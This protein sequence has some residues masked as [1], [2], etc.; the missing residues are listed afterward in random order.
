MKQLKHKEVANSDIHNFSL[1]TSESDCL[2][3]TPALQ[4]IQ[5]KHSNQMQ[6]PRTLPSQEIFVNM[7]T[8]QTIPVQYMGMTSHNLFRK[9]GQ[10]YTLCIHYVVL[11]DANLNLGIKYR[12]L[13]ER[14]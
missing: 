6:S 2:N 9:L 3:K 14:I 1:A 10:R 4:T 12:Q 5:R 7:V 11:N 13:F 8:G